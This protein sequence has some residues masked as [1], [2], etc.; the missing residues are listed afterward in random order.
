MATLDELGSALKNADEAGDTEAARRLANAY[1]KKRQQMQSSAGGNSEG[2]PNSN[3]PDAVQQEM[4]D[5]DYRGSTLDRSIRGFGSGL[6][7]VVGAPAD[8]MNWGLNQFGAGVERP[9]LGSE[10]I[11]SALSS[12]G[13]APESGVDAE[14]GSTLAGSIGQGAGVAG[15]TLIPLFGAANRFAQS[16]R[17]ATAS[18]SEG[19]GARRAL[20]TMLRETNNA[21]GAAAASETAGNVGASTGQYAAQENGYEPGSW[22]STASQVGG[23]LLGSLSPFAASGVARAAGAA[24]NVMPLPKIARTTAERINVARGGDYSRDTMNTAADV[25]QDQA[26]DVSR[27]RMEMANNGG[28]VDNLSPAQQTGDRGLMAIANRLNR[29]TPAAEEAARR[30]SENSAE[31]AQG[32]VNSIGENVPLARTG[33]ELQR[34]LQSVRDRAQSGNRNIQQRAQQAEENLG[35]IRSRSDVSE[36]FDANVN[37]AYDEARGQTQSLWNQVDQDQ[38]VNTD[39]LIAQLRSE[40]DDAGSVDQ[41]F[42]GD[43]PGPARRL[44]QQGEDAQRQNAAAGQQA[45]DMG[46]ADATDQP[47]QTSVREMQNLRRVL[48]QR[49]ASAGS[50]ANPDRNRARIMNNL[51]GAIDDDLETATGGAGDSLRRAVQGTRQMSERFRRNPATNNIITRSGTGGERVEPEQALERAV[52]LGSQGSNSRGRSGARQIDQAITESFTGDGSG[53]P[54]SSNGPQIQRNVEDYLTGEFARRARGGDGNLDARRAQQFVRDNSEVLDLPQFSQLQTRLRT[55]ADMRRRGEDTQ[56]RMNSLFDRLQDP[57]QSRAAM[58]MG[59][60]TDDGS[61]QNAISNILNG[62]SGDNMNQIMR[63]VRRDETGDALRGLKSGFTRQMMARL[64]GRDG[65]PDGDRMA[66]IVGSRSTNDMEPEDASMARAARQLFNETERNRISD[67]AKSLS[68]LRQSAEVDPTNAD[69]SGGGINLLTSL[70]AKYSGAQ[71]GGALGGSAGGSMQGANIF[72]R[73]LDQSLGSFL[74]S[75]VEQALGD[76][77][78]DPRLMRA[79]LER[80]TS[81]RRLLSPRDA[82]SRII[83]AWLSQVPMNEDLQRQQNEQQQ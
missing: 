24:G 81:E 23:G 8:L 50:G 42:G 79:L 77:V 43:V 72:S 49:A 30:Q 7:D 64:R 18:A 82:N 47:V 10:N 3:Q 52:P 74:R 75:P 11:E 73:L 45:R 28:N 63:Q 31:S 56:Q 55:A 58:F 46:N 35:P 19:S 12:V 14:A 2:Q 25:L 83:G 21:R 59:R 54:A 6:S 78:A 17:A 15:G 39:N 4:N 80:N 41:L 66:D 22:Q 20:D 70:A 1:E 33:E 13:L 53:L 34:R 16:G 62:D 5:G 29:R 27:A 32:R 67:A 37:A 26:S 48:G 60:S 51:V 71:L 69:L 9:W 44:L 61:Y 36:D 40:V 65:L 57:R 68:R 38:Q 76:A